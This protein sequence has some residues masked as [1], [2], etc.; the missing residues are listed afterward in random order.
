MLHVPR[1]NAVRLCTS[2]LVTAGGGLP[3]LLDIDPATGALKWGKRMD[4]H[5]AA[6]IT[7]S[8]TIHKHFVYVGVS[9]LEELSAKS[10]NYPCCTFIGS[11]LKVELASGK[12]VWRTYMAP[13]NG[14]ST[15]GFSGKRMIFCSTASMLP[16]MRH[17]RWLLLAYLHLQTT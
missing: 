7:Q 14:N 2:L 12:V 10:P 13:P 1:G 8:A 11:M 4:P 5:P 6:M 17:V 16:Y 9:S 3:Y 15:G